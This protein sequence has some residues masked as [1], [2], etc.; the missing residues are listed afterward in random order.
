MNYWAMEAAENSP[1]SLMQDGQLSDA[2][3][4]LGLSPNAAREAISA[5]DCEPM[6]QLF[7]PESDALA[8]LNLAVSDCT[9]CSWIP[10]FSV[11]ARDLCLEFGSAAEDFLPCR[12]TTQPGCIFFLHLPTDVEHVVDVG[13][14]E[15]LMTIPADP[16]IPFHITKLVLSS[17]PRTGCFRAAIPGHQQVFAELMASLAF[18]DAWSRKGLTGARFRTLDKSDTKQLQAET[19]PGT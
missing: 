14:S 3:H 15:F 1:F 10:V 4:R 9:F 8:P 11:A 12:F 18:K 16:P 6:L 5:S 13:Q 2:V 17:E 19:V 7:E